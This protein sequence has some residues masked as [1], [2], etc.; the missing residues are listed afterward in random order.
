MRLGSSS[1]ALSRGL[2]ADRTEGGGSHG[3]SRVGA[4]RR[5]PIPPNDNKNLE[6]QCRGGRAE[7]GLVTEQSVTSVIDPSDPRPNLDV[8]TST[9]WPARRSLRDDG[10][11]RR[12]TMT[13]LEG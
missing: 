9:E 4:G 5:A 1:R 6:L 11:F 2:D 3:S 7:A 13:F 8:Q 10:S 12:R